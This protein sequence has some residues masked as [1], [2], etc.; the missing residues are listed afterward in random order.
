MRT[1]IRIK[2]RKHGTAA[3]TPE[4]RG[5]HTRTACAFEHYKPR[6]P[7][8]LAAREYPEHA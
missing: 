8:S 1:N 7:Q 2:E 3:E 4:E 5:T 6:D